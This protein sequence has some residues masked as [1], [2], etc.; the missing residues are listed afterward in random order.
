MLG[1]S[2]RESSGLVLKIGKGKISVK[3]ISIRVNSSRKDKISQGDNLAPRLR[4]GHL[5]LLAKT[6]DIP[7]LGRLLRAKLPTFCADRQGRDVLSIL[8]RHRLKDR[9]LERKY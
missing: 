3:R 2:S 8:L 9:L 4:I 1:K 5:G 7:I 6:V